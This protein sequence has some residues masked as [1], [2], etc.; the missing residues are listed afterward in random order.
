MVARWGYE[1]LS[2]NQFMENEYDKMFYPE[3]RVMSL[4]EYKKNY[5]IKNLQN[6]IDFLKENYD[7]PE[8]LSKNESSLTLLRNELQKELLFLKTLHNSAIQNIEYPYIDSLY[9][10][11]VN[12]RILAKTDSL[13]RLINRVYIKIYNQA[14]DKRDAL[15]REMQKTP[16]G[17]ESFQKLK[18]NY[19]NDKLAEFVENNNEIVRIIEYKGRLYQKIDPIYMTPE[20]RF[21]KAHF[22]APYKRVFGQLYDTFWVNTLVIWVFSIIMFIILYFRGLKRLLDTIEQMVER[23]KKNAEG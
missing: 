14:N 17:K 6:K 13:T 2:V 10:G 8:S 11:S 15:I 16:E 5:W 21:L 4:A 22:Y 20:P 19:H 18:S 3:N 1:A 7:N 9:P 12:P 23:M